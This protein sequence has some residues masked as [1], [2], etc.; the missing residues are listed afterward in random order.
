MLTRDEILARKNAR[1]GGTEQ[2]KLSDGSGTVTIRGLTRNEAIRVRDAEG[3]LSARDDLLIS[4]GLVDPPMSQQDVAEWGETEG[5]F[6][7]ITDL[8][9]A[10]GRLSGMTEGAGKSR[11]PRTRK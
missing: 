2:Y 7:V 3:G 4:I 10:I 5:D 8:S 1:A 11:V 9:E 6:V